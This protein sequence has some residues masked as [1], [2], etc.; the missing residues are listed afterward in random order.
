MSKLVVKKKALML[1]I[2][3]SLLLGL[4][5][6]SVQAIPV[7]TPVATPPGGTYYGSEAISLSDATPGSIILYCIDCQ[8]NPDS[9]N[10][11]MYTGPIAISDSGAVTIK[12][13][14]YLNAPGYNSSPVMVETYTNL[15]AAG[16]FIRSVSYYSGNLP[17]TNTV[18]PDTLLVEFSEPIACIGFV[19][20]PSNVFNYIGNLENPLFSS[21]VVF[22]GTCNPDNLAD[23]VLIVLPVSGTVSP[24]KDSLQIKP[25]MLQDQYGNLSPING[26]KTVIQ[27]GEYPTSVQ[28]N[29]KTGNC[30]GCGTGTGLAFF[31]P[32][33]FKLWSRKK[34]RRAKG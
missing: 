15:D 13:I 24:G 23:S 29:Q 31:P 1:K 4:V 5:V 32:I 26:Q 33:G 10:G 34:R 19:Q 2:G 7:A 14:S 9:V 18:K 11:L 12:A 25:A 6:V 21:N 17:G 30:G 27:K 22:L 16:P 8:G 20:Y 3:F 28:D